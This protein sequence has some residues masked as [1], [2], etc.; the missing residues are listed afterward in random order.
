ML[1]DVTTQLRPL[2]RLGVCFPHYLGSGSFFSQV[3]PHSCAT[4]P[5]PLRWHWPQSLC[6][7]AVRVTLLKMRGFWTSF[8]FQVLLLPSAENPR[9]LNARIKQPDDLTAVSMVQL[10]FALLVL[11]RVLLY[12]PPPLCGQFSPLVGVFLSSPFPSSHIRSS[13]S[14]FLLILVTFLLL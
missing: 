10:S 3:D 14:F 12:P 11:C 9:V 13:F 8:C 5:L 6:H 2:L 7:I 4:T 1:K